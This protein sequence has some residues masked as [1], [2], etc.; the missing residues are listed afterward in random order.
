MVLPVAASADDQTDFRAVQVPV[1]MS[2]CESS[3]LLDALK[4][5]DEQRTL[6]DR[7]LG[8]WRTDFLAAKKEFDSHP[9]GSRGRRSVSSR[10]KGLRNAISDLLDD[11]QHQLFHQMLA[12]WRQSPANYVQA[13]QFELDLSAEQLV[14]LHGLQTQWTLYALA[15]VPCD[16]RFPRH[17]EPA[18]PNRVANYRDYSYA[19]AEAAWKFAPRRNAAWNQIVTPA[20]SQRWKERELQWAFQVNG[21]PIL[22]VDFS[23]SRQGT[24]QLRT[25]TVL[26]YVVPYYTPPFDALKWTD[27]QVREVNQLIEAESVATREFPSDREQRRVWFEE[28]SRRKAKC[29]LLIE[30]IMTPEQQKTWW[31]LVGELSLAGN[32]QLEMMKRSSLAARQ[33]QRDET[34]PDKDQP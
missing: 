16:Y 30:Q 1:E 14:R 26:D 9:E 6:I 4:L 23:P 12:L 15:E 32:F 17:T 7:R 27:D 22:T 21:F 25:G 34:T 19:V 33:S 11:H 28:E 10:D 24:G 20:Q 18:D 3:E 13:Y 31:R 29:M 5:T 2:V 8:Q